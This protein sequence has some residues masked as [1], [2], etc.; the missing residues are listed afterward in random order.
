MYII[1]F[2][3]LVFILYLFDSNN[4]SEFHLFLHLF[5]LYA[6]CAT[7]GDL[8]EVKLSLADLGKQVDRLNERLEISNS[9]N[10]KSILFLTSEFNCLILI[11]TG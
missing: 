2:P 10:V 9:L 4:L 11:R 1:S 6:Q 7:I 8:L 5:F 3:H